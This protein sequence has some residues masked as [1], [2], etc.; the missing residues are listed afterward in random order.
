LFQDKFRA[1]LLYK[2]FSSIYDFVN[3]FFYSKEMRREL[4]K[5]AEVREKPMMILDEG[6]GSAYTAEEL[7][8]RA[9]SR[10]T[11]VGVDLSINMLSKA[12][13]RLREARMSWHL[14]LGDVEELPF[15]GNTFDLVTSAGVMEYL[16]DCLKAV[17]E[18][19]RVLKRGGRAI[20]LAPK[21]P[22]SLPLRVLAKSVM[23]FF[24]TEQCVK[25]MAKSGMKKVSGFSIG[26]RKLM[27]KLAVVIRGEKLQ[28]DASQRSS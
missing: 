2:F 25:M 11:I 21:E 17:E 18:I 9:R 22:D 23:G 3:P 6:I 15:R 4:V 14:V 26:P 7:A 16:P 28:T 10:S 24:T 8:R 12:K 19:A 20:I 5:L 13:V 1:K 27:S